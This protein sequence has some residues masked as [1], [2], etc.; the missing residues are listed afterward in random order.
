M[1]RN[2]RE[3]RVLAGLAVEERKGTSDPM[4]AGYAA[5]YNVETDI[6]GFFRERIAPGAFAD[7]ITKASADVHALFNHDSNI[8]LGRM[9]AGATNCWP[10]NG[11]IEVVGASSAP[12]MP[13]RPAPRLKVSM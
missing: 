11:W 12:D 4:L 3:I 13:A 6:A 10:M 7:A 2:E 1:T 5:V 8:V 9:K